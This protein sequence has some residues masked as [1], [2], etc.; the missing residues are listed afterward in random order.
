[1]YSHFIFIVASGLLVRDLKNKWNKP[2]ERQETP[3]RTFSDQTSG[4]HLFKSHGLQKGGNRINRGSLKTKLSLKTKSLLPIM[5]E[6]GVALALRRQNR[7][8]NADEGPMKKKERKSTASK[9]KGSK[10][11]KKT[12]NRSWQIFVEGAALYALCL[13]LPNILGVIVRFCQQKWNDQILYRQVTTYICSFSCTANT[14]WCQAEVAAASN[15]GATV[16]APDAGISDVGVVVVLSLS[17]AVVRV[18]LVH[19]LVPQYK[20]PERLEAL[21]RCKSVHLLSSSYPG[22][23]TP[24]KRLSL[25]IIGD[26][27]ALPPLPFLESETIKANNLSPRRESSEEDLLTLEQN[28]FNIA[29]S[30]SGLFVDSDDDHEEAPEDQEV[31]PAPVVSSG[32]LTSSSAHSLQHLLEQAQVKTVSPVA[33]ANEQ[34]EAAERIFA[35]PKYATAVFR[36]MYC[37]ACILIALM[38]F[39]DAEFWPAAVGGRGSSKHCWDL[40]SVTAAVME[41]DFDNHNVVLRRYFLLQGSYHFHSAAFHLLTSLLLWLV[42]SSR[43]NREKTTP[44][45][46]GFIPA[47]IITLDNIKIFLQHSLSVSLLAGTYIFSSLRRLAAIGM[48]AFDVSSWFLHLLQLCI[49]APPGTKRISPTWVWILH[50]GLVIPSFCY[51]R[52]YVF[53]FVIGYSALVESQDWLKQLEKMSIPGAAMY[54]RALFAVWVSLLMFMNVVYVRRLM[55]H[56][57]V[58]QALD[59]PKKER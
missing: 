20:Q 17:M 54:M 57:H 16:L 11:D 35:A 18:A 41:S 28:I 56:P 14:Q 44:K 1:V 38:F 15:P 47:G 53:P 8:L 42:S 6:V 45:I 12:T 22:T 50:R 3:V 36:L 27:Q 4:N 13:L 39:S 21:V 10:M 48:F 46:L 43:K 31:A 7:L 29:A 40:S 37:T 32:L 55:Y 51:S 49:N 2:V 24:T 9:P 34:N 26:E 33:T 58:L 19:Y 52:F 25:S 30:G 23:V 5:T 59:Q